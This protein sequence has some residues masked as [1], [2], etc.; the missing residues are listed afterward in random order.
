ME[1]LANILFNKIVD[2]NDKGGRFINS[3]YGN[4]KHFNSMQREYL[5]IK[6]YFAILLVTTGQV[7]KS[8]NEANNLCGMIGDKLYN[9]ITSY[10]VS[11]YG[12]SMGELKE[13][14]EHY[15]NP[16]TNK[17]N[18]ILTLALDFM[19][20]AG[21]HKNKRATVFEVRSMLDGTFREMCDICMNNKPTS[22]RTQ[23]SGC[24][25]AVA[26]FVALMALM[27]MI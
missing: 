17:N 1:K 10:P 13:R 21:D 25:S 14:L 20:F 5:Y 16:Q 24:L 19:L 12:A 15:S 9:R 27:C 18:D 4:T 23:N 7:C 2:P 11:V 6:A 26:C 3:R 22:R 8:E